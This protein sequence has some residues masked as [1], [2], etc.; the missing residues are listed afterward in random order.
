[1]VV[2]RSEE[3][4]RFWS[5]GTE[6]QLRRM[7]T[8]RAIMC[9][10]VTTVNTTGLHPGH[11]LRV[12]FRGSHLPPPPTSTHKG[13]CVRRWEMLIS[14]TVVIISLCISHHV[15]HLKYNFI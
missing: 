6:W 13:N 11:L 8:S 12:N 7:K 5:E 9:S 3:L 14:L 4:R 10:T 1:M 15:V 2:T